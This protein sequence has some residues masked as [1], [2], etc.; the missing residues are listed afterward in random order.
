MIGFYFSQRRLTIYKF[1]PNSKSGRIEISS[2]VNRQWRNER[3]MVSSQIR[4]L[5]QGVKFVITPSVSD[6]SSVW[7]K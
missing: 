5:Q 7:R 6:F 3:H 4:L 2:S 1:G